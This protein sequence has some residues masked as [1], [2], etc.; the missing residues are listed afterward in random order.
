MKKSNLWA[1]LW[2]HSKVQ[3]ILNFYLR[4]GKAIGTSQ[5]STSFFSNSFSGL[6]RGSRKTPPA[7]KEQKKTS[8]NMQHLSIICLANNVP[9]KTNG[10]SPWLTT[11]TSAAGIIVSDPCDSQRLKDRRWYVYVC[12]KG[13]LTWMN[14]RRL[15][16][17]PCAHTGSMRRMRPLPEWRAFLRH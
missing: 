14:V 5:K 4:Q 10:L 15:A 1:I 7:A 17:S 9:T 16:M 13:L 11:S 3:K 8:F 12:M 2:I 6:H